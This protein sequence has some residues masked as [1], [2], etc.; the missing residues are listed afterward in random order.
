MPYFDRFDIC[1]AYYL[2][3]MFWN[4]GGIFQERLHDPQRQGS[5]ERSVRNESTGVQLSRV[6]FRP[7]DLKDESSLT[8]N[9]QEIY[10]QLIDRLIPKRK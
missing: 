10:H 7:R 1:E 6:E 8:E 5:L 4:T 3:E 2:A 9:G